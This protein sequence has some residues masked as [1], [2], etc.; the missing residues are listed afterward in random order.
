MDVPGYTTAL[1]EGSLGNAV[2]A[3]KL[4]GGTDED[5]G[6]FGEFERLLGIR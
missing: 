3:G 4:V 2:S 1:A 6:N 5:A